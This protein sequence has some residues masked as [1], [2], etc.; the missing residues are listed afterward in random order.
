MRW[1]FFQRESHCHWTKAKGIADTKKISVRQEGIQ[2][3]RVG[4]EYQEESE[5]D[6]E[7]YS[8]QNGFWFWM[9]NRRQAIDHN[10]SW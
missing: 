8:A 4:N 10:D 5:L 2:E 9:D 7:H 1:H 6:P 3:D